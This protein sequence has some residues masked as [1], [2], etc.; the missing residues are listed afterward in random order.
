[1][2]KI[3]P[4][5]L[6]MN[7]GAA[8]WVGGGGTTVGDE[9]ATPLSRR[10]NSCAESAE[11]GGA[12]TS[13]AGR[14]SFAF[15]TS[16][17]SGALTGGGTT[18]TL[19]IRTRVDGTSVPLVSGAGAIT[20]AVSAGAER[21]G[22][23]ET[24]VGAGATTFALSAG[25]PRTFCRE[26]FGA[27]PIMLASGRGAIRACSDG[28][29]GAG[30]T[31][32]EFRESAERDCSEAIFGAGG[33]TEFSVSPLRECSLL[34]SGAGAITRAESAGALNEECRPSTAG[35][36]AIGS[37]GFDL[38]ASRFATAS[39]DEGSLRSG[40]STTFAD[41]ELPREMRMVCVRW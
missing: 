41:C 35:A 10:R 21:D 4:M 33:T 17:R 32:A 14:L 26:I 30:G 18:A 2:P 20:R 37:A 9:A 38:Y 36:G 7:D 1:M 13:G 27:G 12:I 23:A 39:A 16:S 19:V 40:A 6:L 31:T 8:G 5:M 24:C 28:A 3:L 22:A 29:V 25:A 15:L 34:I 11:G